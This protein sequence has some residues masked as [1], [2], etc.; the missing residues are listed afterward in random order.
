MKRTII[1]ILTGLL[2]IAMLLAGGC[3]EDEGEVSSE[4]EE[5]VRGHKKL[6]YYAP[7]K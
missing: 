6:S 1:L 3:G 2:V 5:K 7:C 4:H